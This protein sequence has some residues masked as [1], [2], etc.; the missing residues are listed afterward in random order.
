MM[1]W[2]SFIMKAFVGL[3]DTSGLR[4]FLPEDA[5][6]R[7]LL[8]QVA[9]DWLSSATTVI[10]AVVAEDDA[11]MIRQELAVGHCR[12]ACEMLLNRAVELLP[13][14]SVVPEVSRA[15]IAPQ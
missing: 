13:L 9:R 2:Y 4:Q 3:V 5:I 6:P 12:I 11:E 1:M 8:R 10:W 7:N 14:G 15:V